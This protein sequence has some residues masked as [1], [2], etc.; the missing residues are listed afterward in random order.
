MSN[1]V[2]TFKEADDDSESSDDDSDS[3][4]ENFIAKLPKMESALARHRGTINRLRVSTYLANNR[5]IDNTC[6]FHTVAS[7]L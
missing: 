7:V 5:L 1:L 3:E 2:K 4:D 6:L